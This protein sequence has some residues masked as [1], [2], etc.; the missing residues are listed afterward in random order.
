VTLDR[1]NGAVNVGDGLALGWLS[2]EYFAILGE[3]NYRGGS[4][5]TFSVSDN[6]G[7]AT[8]E[9]GNNRVGC[10]EVNAYCT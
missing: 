7:L 2:N 4:T 9:Y 5:E 1:R 10:S 8:F 3:R 6:G